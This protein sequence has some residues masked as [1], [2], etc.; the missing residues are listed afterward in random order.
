MI[1]TVFRMSIYL[2]IGLSFAVYAYTQEAVSNPDRVDNGTVVATVVDEL[3]LQ[4]QQALRAHCANS[5]VQFHKLDGYKHCLAEHHLAYV[6][7]EWC[8]VVN[9]YCEAQWYPFGGKDRCFRE[10]GCSPQP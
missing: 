8:P 5:Q 4:E 10:R 9:K 7:S 2:M 1:S 6:Q 3:P